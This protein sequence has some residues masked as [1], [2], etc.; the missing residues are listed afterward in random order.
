MEQK[1][2]EMDRQLRILILR[3]LGLDQDEV[4]GVLHCAKSSVVEGERWFRNL[5][6]DE[7]LA[8]VNDQRIKRLI[9]DREFR[10]LELDNDNFIKAGRITADDILLHYGHVRPGNAIAEGGTVVPKYAPRLEEHWSKLRQ[11][12][13]SVSRT[14]VSTEHPTALLGRGVPDGGRRGRVRSTAAVH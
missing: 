14:T 7:A 12:G 13:G 10:K 8:L 4:A 2:I 1:K 5:P 3:T 6:Q 9:D 11:R